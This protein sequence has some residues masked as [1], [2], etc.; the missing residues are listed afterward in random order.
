M[1]QYEL[2]ND[3]IEEQR[4]I[5]EWIRKDDIEQLYIYKRW[6]MIL[7]HLLCNS[8]KHIIWQWRRDGRTQKWSCKENVYQIDISDV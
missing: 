1:S 6:A 4:E 8:G 5:K 2:T 3:G 7:N